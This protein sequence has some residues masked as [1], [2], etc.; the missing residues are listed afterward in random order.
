MFLPGVGYTPPPPEGLP[1]GRT[2]LPE[3]LTLKGLSQEVDIWID[4]LTIY[5]DG[6]PSGLQPKYQIKSCGKATLWNAFQ[7]S[8][9][10]VPKQV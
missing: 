3:G 9:F 2:T 7:D 10:I 6:S 1:Q 4:F 5:M 8:T